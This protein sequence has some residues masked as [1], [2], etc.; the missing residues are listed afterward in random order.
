ME[1]IGKYNNI[2]FI[3]LLIFLN[4]KY[5]NYDSFFFLRMIIMIVADITFGM[6]AFVCGT[7]YYN[8]SIYYDDDCI[9]SIYYTI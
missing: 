9:W 2:I 5:D 8:I 7:I 3:S 1:C 4:I 6:I